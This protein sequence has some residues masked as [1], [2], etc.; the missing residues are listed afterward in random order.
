MDLIRAHCLRRLLIHNVTHDGKSGIR[1]F[2][3]FDAPDLGAWT[4][5]RFSI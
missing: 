5:Y 2:R 4:Y 3:D 1:P